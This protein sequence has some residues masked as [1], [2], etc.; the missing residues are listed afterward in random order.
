MSPESTSAREA[1]R[2]A[3]ADATI[4]AI[5]DVLALLRRVTDA[6]RGGVS[7]ESQLRHLAAW[8]TAVGTE[9]AAHALFDAAF[10]LGAPRHVSV[11]YPDAEAIASRSSWWEAPAVELSRTLTESGREPGS[12]NHQPAR[13]DRNDH[14]RFELEVLVGSESRCLV[15]F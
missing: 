12:R 9:E 11:E 7:R 6:R 1:S 14:A 8:F 2:T 10:G 4:G 5:G 13:L 3:L 15:D